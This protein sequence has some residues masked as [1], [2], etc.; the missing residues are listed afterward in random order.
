MEIHVN[1]DHESVILKMCLEAQIWPRL[2]EL[3]D[4][5]RR[6]DWVYLKSYLAAIIEQIWR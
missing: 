5:L 3:R 4:A 1:G 2:S 6:A